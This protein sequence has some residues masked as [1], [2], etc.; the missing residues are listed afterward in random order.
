MTNN[1]VASLRPAVPSRKLGQHGLKLW[2]SMVSSQNIRH[3]V[4]VEM[5]TNASQQLDRAES[6]RE[7]INKDGVDHP[8]EGRT[9]GSSVPASRERGAQLRVAHRAPLGAG[10][11]PA[12]RE[13]EPGVLRS[14]ENARAQAAGRRR[15]SR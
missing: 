13:D 5:L 12:A 2:V 15:V 4:H 9:E 1:K 3:P 7:Q 6:L 11:R 10:D 8:D 14:R